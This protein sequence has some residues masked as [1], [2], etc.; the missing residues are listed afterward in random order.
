MTELKPFSLIRPTLDTP[1]H[2]DFN[3]WKTHDSNW[4]IFLTSCLCPEHQKTFQD[5]PDLAMIDRVDP[6]T[7]EVHQVDGIQ[8]VLMDHCVKDPGFINSN[9]AIVDSIF[10]VFLSNG[11]QPLNPKGLSD[12]IGKP[13]RIDS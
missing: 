7:A 9:T 8:A 2:I 12:K 5:Q 6:E 1:Y 3:W 13:A 11:N 10:R 4:R